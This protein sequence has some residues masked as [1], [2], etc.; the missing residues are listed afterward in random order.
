MIDFTLKKE[1]T[2]FD[3]LVDALKA[4]A[5]KWI[6]QLEQ[7]D[8]GYEHY[9]GRLSL[10]KKR[11]LQEIIKI[12]KD[13]YPE[14]KV[15]F[16]ASSTNSGNSFSYV[17]KEDTRIDGPWSDQTQ[18][19]IPRQYRL[20][21]LYPWQKSVLAS[22]LIFDDRDI[23]LLI[24][25]NGNSGKTSLAMYATC[26]RYAEMLPPVN[27]AKDMMRMAMD[28][29]TATMYFIDMTRSMDKRKLAGMYSAIEQIKNGYLWDDRYKFERKFIDSPTIW[30]FTNKKPEL[31]YLSRDR[32]RFWEISPE[33]EL[34]GAPL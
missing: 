18:L 7:S 32:W 17:M 29:P 8:S 21:N 2:N 24:D 25:Q 10:I 13:N 30:V 11:R 3:T 16:S 26:H 9:Q 6:F 15:H 27:D 28:L 1:G 20:Q 14:L 33:R 34:I 31:S 12:W 22:R 5:K 23:N 4:W 19:Y